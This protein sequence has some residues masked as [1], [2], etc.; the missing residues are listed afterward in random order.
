MPAF[1]NGHTLDS[2]RDWQSGPTKYILIGLAAEKSF[3]RVRRER[4]QHN[5]SN[6]IP[7]SVSPN[8]PIHSPFLSFVQRRSP[9]SDGLRLLQDAT[10]IVD[11]RL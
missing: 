7:M 9:P 5:K 2:V 8:K 4:T 10:P 3:Q 6:P 11:P 1:A